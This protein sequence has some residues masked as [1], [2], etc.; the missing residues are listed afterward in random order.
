MLTINIQEEVEREL[1]KTFSADQIKY[2]ILV[3]P[4]I[5]LII[6]TI[7]GTLLS[8]KVNLGAPI[9]EGLINKNSSFNTKSILVYGA[10][11]GL[12]SGCLITLVGF[13]F[14]SS[15]PAEFFEAA[16]SFTPS[17]ANRFL[18]GG[19]TEEI[20]M[21][22]GIMTLVIWVASKVMKSL[23]STPYWIGICTAAVICAAGHLPIAFSL[24]STPSL[25]LISY[26]M[27]GNSLGGI[28]FE[29]FYWKK[30]LESAFIAHM[31][32]HVSML[33]LEPIL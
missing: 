10:M 31:F 5:L 32:A 16:E 2:L 7:L 22:F 13:I 8:K 24:V 17:I 18:Y 20:L 4:T 11:G 29:W 30:G 21:R 15:I 14:R 6:T 12:I 25:T 23:S 1:L 26:I 28:I 19:F 3:N 9:L 27:I 33:T